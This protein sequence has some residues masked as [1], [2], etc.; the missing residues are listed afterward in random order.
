MSLK[1]KLTVRTIF[2]LTAEWLIA[3]SNYLFA[4]TSDEMHTWEIEIFFLN[5]IL[6][7]PIL[8]LIPI[9]MQKSRER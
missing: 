3:W 7:R 9:S 2:A 5:I 6:E 4:Q 8:I 1:F